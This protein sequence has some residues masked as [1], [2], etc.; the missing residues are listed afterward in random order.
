MPHCTG[1]LQCYFVF[2]VYRSGWY[3]KQNGFSY[4]IK[5]KLVGHSGG[6]SNFPF[7]IEARFEL[8]SLLDAE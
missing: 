4:H 8:M 7:G 5:N 1:K 3:F 2:L 6:S